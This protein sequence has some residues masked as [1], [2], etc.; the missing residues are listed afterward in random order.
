LNVNASYSF[1][2]L[3]KESLFIMDIYNVYNRRDIFFRQFL[4]E[5]DEVSVQDIKLLPIIPSISWEINF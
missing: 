4:V 1:E 2:I 5:D 3:G